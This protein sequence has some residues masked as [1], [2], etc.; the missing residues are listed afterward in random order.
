MIVQ[1]LEKRW[2]ASLIVVENSPPEHYHFWMDD[3]K[4]LKIEDL[5]IVRNLLENV[6]LVGGYRASDQ[7]R[8]TAGGENIM[9]NLKEVDPEYLEARDRIV[10]AG[11]N[12]NQDDMWNALKVCT[13]GAEVSKK[14]FSSEEEAVGQEVRISG[15][16]FKVIGVVDPKTED[17]GNS[18]VAKDVYIPLTTGQRRFTGDEPLDEIVIKARSSRFTD[19]AKIQLADILYQQHHKWDF[20]IFSE[21][22]RAQGIQRVVTMVQGILAALAMISLIVGGIVVMN[23]MLVSVT[24][25]TPEIGLRKSLGA[26][27]KDIVIQFLSETLAL[28]LMSGLCGIILG[29]SLAFAITEIVPHFFPNLKDW[30]WSISFPALAI[31]FAC[32]T[33]VGLGSG[34]YP[35]WRA[36]KLDPTVA[37]RYE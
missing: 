19:A 20:L 12:I 28:C 7:R 14:L 8:V 4:N 18:E 37:L 23:T 35:A 6:E 11:R 36:A 3:W 34:V 5:H 31:A 21:I 29:L 33:L 1:E 26:R 2:G 25:R 10:R 16:R 22:E 32:S 9:G 17:I 13:I 15:E 24:E 30:P 27:R